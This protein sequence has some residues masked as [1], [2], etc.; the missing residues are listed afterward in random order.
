MF[1]ALVVIITGNLLRNVL[2]KCTRVYIYIYISGSPS[3]GLD[4][5]WHQIADAI[6]FNLPYKLFKMVEY[7]VTDHDFRFCLDLQID[8]VQAASRRSV[9]EKWRPIWLLNMSFLDRTG[10]CTCLLPNTYPHLRSRTHIQIQKS[11]RYVFEPLGSPKSMEM[12]HIQKG[13]A[14]QIPGRVLHIPLVNKNKQVDTPLAT[15]GL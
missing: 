4:P 9:L 1:T 8:R 7:D 6:S 15:K 2:Q 14:P 5:I 11:R 12:I 13:H 10:Y 3:G